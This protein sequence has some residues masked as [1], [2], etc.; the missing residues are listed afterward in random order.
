MNSILIFILIFS[1]IV[2]LVNGQ[3]E[4]LNCR[5]VINSAFG[6]VCDLTIIN[7]SGLNNFNGING[8]H[9]DGKTD[10]DVVFI[11]F[12][13]TG[14][15]SSNIPSIICQKFPNLVRIQ[16]NNFGL[17]MIDDFSFKNCKN[18]QYIHLRN[19]K[20]NQI[21]ENS[22]QNNP[23][24]IELFLEN[25]EI[26]VLPENLLMNLH[27]LKGLDFGTNRI[28]SLPAN[29]FSQL[30]SLDFLFLN[31]NLL[32][33]LP[34]NVFSGLKN[35][36]MIYLNSNKLEVIHAYP[37]GMLP[38]LKAVNLHSNQIYAIDE[39][40]IDNTSVNLIHMLNNICANKRI[41]DLPTR[42]VLRAELKVCFDNYRKTFG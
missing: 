13:K 36:T 11:M 18:V 31:E 6:Y 29:F 39:K 22:F 4:V 40:F 30:I 21:H 35:M 41:E 27:K 17:R 25:N 34:A 1:T 26:A 23:E 24:L 10:M 37:F 38:K 9:L 20:I 33:D 28:S 16:L 5:Y 42:Y 8:T 14:S 19:N 3:N 7:P 2:C 12:Y 15:N 32:K